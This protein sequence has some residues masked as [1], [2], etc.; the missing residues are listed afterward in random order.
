MALK[1]IES[2]QSRWR[3]VN[4]THLV[5][6]ILAGAVSVNGVLAER[7]DGEDALSTETPTL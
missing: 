4:A 6:L 3:A 1:L 2:P 5:T 7:S